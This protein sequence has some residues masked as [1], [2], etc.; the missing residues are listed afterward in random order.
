MLSHLHSRWFIFFQSSVFRNS[1][2]LHNGKQ[3]FALTKIGER[4]LSPNSE[5]SLSPVLFIQIYTLALSALLAVEA[6][7]P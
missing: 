7:E 5:S 3:G 1:E 2:K 4:L 6:L